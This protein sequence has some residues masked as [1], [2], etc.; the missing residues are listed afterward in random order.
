MTKIKLA[1]LSLL[2][3]SISFAC[4]LY[5]GTNHGKEQALDNL[6]NVCYSGAI[7]VK[8]NKVVGCWP[9]S[10][11]GKEEKKELDNFKEPWYNRSILSNF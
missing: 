8:D 9:M 4:G 1:F 11:V 5:L 3:S 6:F 10:E 2:I 7:I